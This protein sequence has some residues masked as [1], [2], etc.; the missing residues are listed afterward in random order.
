MKLNIQTLY[1]I[2][3]F[4]S[5]GVTN[6]SSSI[7]M[8]DGYNYYEQSSPLMKV[9]LLGDYYFQ[10]LKTKYYR[11]IS[12]EFIKY[13]THRLDNTKPKILYQAHTVV[14]TY[15]STLCIQY[16][17]SSLDTA[18]IDDIK[19]QLKN[20]L[21]I[22]P[23]KIDKIKCGL[24]SAYKLQYQTSNSFNK[25][26]ISHTEYFFRQGEYIYRLFFW[27]TNSDDSIISE[28]AEFII[29]GIRFG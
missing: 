9:Q 3:I 14:Q 5:C 16:K 4:T 2:L 24:T 1:F 25:I 20:N 13:A 26:A 8:V 18:I 21:N 27:T 15:Y 6:K 11:D 10:P 22:K 7:K 29:K 17:S 23:P 12:K 28:E 19:L